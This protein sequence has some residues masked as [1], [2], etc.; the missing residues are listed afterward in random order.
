[1]KKNTLKYDP[2]IA[3][4]E[5]FFQEGFVL[6]PD[7]LHFIDSTFSDPSLREFE[8]ILKDESNLERESLIALLFSPDES[9]HRN[10]EDVLIHEMYGTDDEKIITG[11][12]CSKK[13]HT[14]VIFPDGRG[15][16]DLTVP[17]GTVASFISQL[18][19]HWK[20]EKAILETLDRIVDTT[21]RP[22]PDDRA[23]AIKPAVTVRM[24]TKRS[25][26]SEIKINTLCLFLE[27]SDWQNPLFFT[28][29]D[30]LLDTMD[31]ISDSDDIFDIL[32][33]RKHQFSDAIRKREE[34]ESLLEK[35]NPEILI[36]Q[37]MRVPF[38]NTDD[39]RK[40]IEIIDTI[41]L[42]VYGK[43]VY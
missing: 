7:V 37:G 15:E 29:L 22:D 5:H 27:N 34:F 23:D 35:S 39:M 17:D 42:A 10:L 12:M 3:K 40:R 24:R 43:I 36:Q 21:G 38:V 9:I 18:H 8:M 19:I 1:M 30:Y 2:L 28:G 11:L 26:L 13:L 4:I 32:S 41:T 25:N 20:P 6:S 31:G 16:L 33:R 14:R